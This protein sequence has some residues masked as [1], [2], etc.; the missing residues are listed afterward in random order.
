MNNNKTLKHLANLTF[1]LVAS[2]QEKFSQLAD[3]RGLS[4]SEFK[5]LRLFGTD[6]H[7][8][9]KKIAKRMNLSASR[10]TRIIDGLVSKGYM[11]RKYDRM[12]WRS[13][14]LNL[15]RKGKLFINK[16]N[17]SFYD[18][19]Y[20]ILKETKISQHKPLIKL[21]EKLNSATEIWMNKSVKNLKHK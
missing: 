13:L 17:M 21:I 4:H 15:S 12:D 16:L 1:H 10:S 20:Q 6:K 9:N 5:C 2:Y 11:T 14:D 7:L 3:K 19:N 18:M 8:N